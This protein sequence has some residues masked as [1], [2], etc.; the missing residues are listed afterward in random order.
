MRLDYILPGQVTEA[1]KC[2]QKKPFTV[3]ID[4]ICR[5]IIHIDDVQFSN[6]VKQDF[7]KVVSTTRKELAKGKELHK[8]K[9][10]PVIFS[11]YTTSLRKS[12]F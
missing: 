11:Y 8:R 3:R 2:Y 10:V 5:F 6:L 9:I 4:P 7:K 1:F 12:S